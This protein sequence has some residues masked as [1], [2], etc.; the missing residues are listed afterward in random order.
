M[1]GKVNAAGEAALQAYYEALLTH[2][3][4]TSTTPANRKERKVAFGT[5]KDVV[6]AQGYKNTG[7]LLAAHECAALV[8]GCHWV[9]CKS[10]KDR[11]SMLVTHQTAINH[12]AHLRDVNSERVMTINDVR[13]LSSELRE[14][15]VRLRNC[16]LNTGKRSYAFNEM[17]LLTLPEEL[18]P[19]PGTFGGG[20][21]S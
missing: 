15:G 16:E 13:M 5:L 8:G 9:S 21:Q 12:Q 3:R 14:H 2:E 4:A 19:P 17:Q 18:R 6:A 10:A 20:A 7:I 1:H 11:T